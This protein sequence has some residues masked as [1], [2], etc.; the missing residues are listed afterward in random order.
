[1]GWP[2]SPGESSA[3]SY[4]VY[5]IKRLLEE[6]MQSRIIQPLMPS[7]VK[8]SIIAIGHVAFC[9]GGPKKRTKL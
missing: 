9:I 2:S 7:N 4:G 3:K 1:M 5:R 8:G 6:G